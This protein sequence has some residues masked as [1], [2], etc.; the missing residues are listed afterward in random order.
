MVKCNVMGL[1]FS[2]KKHVLYRLLSSTSKLHVHKYI[3]RSKTLKR[4]IETA[5]PFTGSLFP[6]Y[7]NAEAI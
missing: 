2:S 1:T 4:T 3:C 5:L 6:K 7:L